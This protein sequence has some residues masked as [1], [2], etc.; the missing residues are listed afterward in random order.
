LSTDPY[1]KI[2][3]QK[4]RL[5]KRK[6]EIARRKKEKKKRNFILAAIAIASVVL[7]LLLIKQ[8]KKKEM[9]DEASFKKEGELIFL[10]TLTHV[11]AQINI[12]IADNEH[13]RQIGLMNRESLKSNEGMLF[14]FPVSQMQSFWMLNTKFP[15]DIFY[16][17]SNKRII[18][19]YKNTQPLTRKPYPSTAPS[20]YVIEGKGGLADSTG[21]A[22][23]D[24]IRWIEI[25]E[26]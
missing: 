6:V 16:A 19:I 8:V 21:I 11:K 3:E 7:L 15:L 4:K 10:D 9:P 23:G 25:P 2:L 24:E 26:K 22:I 20:Q 14:I 12:E 1:K 5:E 17:D 13:K 18:T